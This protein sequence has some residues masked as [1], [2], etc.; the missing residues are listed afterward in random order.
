VPPDDKETNGFGRWLTKAVELIRRA[1]RADRERKE[2]RWLAAAPVVVAA[3]VLGLMMPRATEP[4][5][6]PLPMLDVRALDAVARADDARAGAAEAE[7]LPADVLSVGTVLREL[8]GADGRGLDD[9]EKAAVRRRLDAALLEVARHRGYEEELL[10]LRALQL[11]RFL[12]ALS[13]WEMSGETGEDFSDLAAAFV[14]KMH[15]AGWLKGRTLLAPERVRRVMFKTVWTAMVGLDDHP[16][17]RLTL[18]EQRALYTF[19]LEHP[20]LPETERLILESLR[21][22]A[23]TPEACARSTAEEQRHAELWR[24]DKI[25]RLGAMDPSYPVEFALG[26]TQF[27]IGRFEQAAESFEAFLAHH[28]SGPY[29]LRAKNHLKASLAASMR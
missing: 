3:L 8:S 24:A 26:V 11:R 9:A 20:R 22:A 19:Y 18:D 1:A 2:G 6:L 7:R 14:E 15:E 28:P 5:V 21:A 29:T 10:A 4:D 23:T 25:K 17:L 13:R 27:R 16:A 12:E